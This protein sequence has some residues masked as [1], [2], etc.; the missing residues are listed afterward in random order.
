MLY[1]VTGLGVTVGFRH[2]LTNG[3][4][5]AVGPLRTALAVAGSTSFQGDVIGWLRDMRCPTPD[6]LA[7]RR[8]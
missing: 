1:A 7:A 5:R 4:S 8:A 2:G 3:G 6:R